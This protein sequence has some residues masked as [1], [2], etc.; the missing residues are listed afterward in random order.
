MKRDLQKR[1]TTAA[2]EIKKYSMPFVRNKKS[3]MKEKTMIET[4]PYNPIEETFDKL[5]EQNEEENEEEVEDES[6]K[7]KEKENDNQN[8]KKPTE[9]EK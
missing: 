3:D 5:D 7:E 1:R 2:K 8:E 4:K 9:K 6:K